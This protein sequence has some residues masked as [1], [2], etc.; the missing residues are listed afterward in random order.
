MPELDHAEFIQRET[1]VWYLIYQAHLATLRSSVQFL[2]QV[3]IC[4]N[5]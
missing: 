3:E 2:V 5:K 1:Q 4:R